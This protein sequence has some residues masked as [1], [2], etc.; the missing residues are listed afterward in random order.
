LAPPNLIGQLVAVSRLVRQRRDVVVPGA[1]LAIVFAMGFLV[2]P[3][4]WT[5]RIRNPERTSLMEQRIREASEEGDSLDIRQDWVPL[6]EVSSDLVRAVLVAE[7]HRFREHRGIDWVSLAEE[8]RW[9]GDDSFS[10]RSASDLR[11][12]ASAIAYVWSNRNEIRGRST[13]TQQLAKNVYFGTERSLLR[14]AREFV[15]AGRLERKL[16]KDRILELYLNIVEWGPGT[17][18]AEAAARTY[19]GQSAASLTVD[20]AA[21]LAAT[22]PHP[23]TSNP[24]RNRG[25]ML[26]RKDLILE[27]LDPSLGVPPAPI[28]LPDPRIELPEPELVPLS[29]PGGPGVDPV[30]PDTQA[31]EPDTLTV[32]PDTLVVQG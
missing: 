23:L 29:V 15:V 3:Y 20:Q 30:L 12:L 8:V 25:R 24:A 9:A 27:R 11:A 4:P 13:I 5:L 19:F 14:K 28:P 31:A 17:F 32:R 10:W 1:A 18:G 22:L 6:E 21:A 7:D 2:L 26:W 16:G